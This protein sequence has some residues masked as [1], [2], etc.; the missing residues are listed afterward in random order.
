MGKI[1]KGLFSSEK[2]YWETP[3]ALFDELNNKYHFTLDPCSTN[4]NA[5][6]KK[7]YTKETNGLLQSWNNEVVFMNPPYGKEISLWVR[8]AYLESSGGGLYYRSFITSEN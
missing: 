7:H 3:K 6:C 8:K 1:T 4:E 2:D 5:K